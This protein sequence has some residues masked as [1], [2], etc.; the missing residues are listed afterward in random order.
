VGKLNVDKSKPIHLCSFYRPPNSST[1]SISRLKKAL[2]KISDQSPKIILAG[3][4]NLSG[5]GW[6]E[7]VGLIHSAPAYRIELNSDIINDHSLEQCVTGK[8]TYWI[9]FF[10]L[11]PM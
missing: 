5:V 8:I 4:F 10:Q 3:D 11:I 7:G 1:D 6:E 2:D 9:W